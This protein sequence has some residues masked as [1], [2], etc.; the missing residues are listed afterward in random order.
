MQALTSPSPEDFKNQKHR[1][2]ELAVHDLL[3][4]LGA[5]MGYSELLQTDQK[6]MTAEETEEII[7]LIND[8]CKQMMALLHDLRDFS[9][10]ESGKLKIQRN[11]CHLENL[12]EE[13]VGINKTLAAKKNISL[14]LTCEPVPELSLDSLR[15]GQVIDNL[16]KNAIKFSPP[17]TQIFIRLDRSGNQARVSIRDE[18]PGIATEDLPFVF[19]PFHKL[20]AKPTAGEHSTRLG[21]ATH[22]KYIENHQGEIWVNSTPGEGAEFIFT[23]PLS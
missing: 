12:L 16:L 19:T 3:N 18:G 10:A 22:K 7:N 13:H 2:L 17:E 8:T 11:P 14:N 9:T 15:I 1:L 6:D 5:L 21:L 20:K 23:L 4:P